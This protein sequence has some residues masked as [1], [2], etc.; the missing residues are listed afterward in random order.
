M[1]PFP[2]PGVFSHSDNRH[3]RQHLCLLCVCV[4]AR[5]L[6]VPGSSQLQC[7]SATS[8]LTFHLLSLPA[9]TA[10]VNT[11]YWQPFSCLPFYFSPLLSPSSV[12]HLPSTTLMTP[13][14]LPFFLLSSQS[15]SP[16]NLPLKGFPIDLMC[17]LPLQ[18]SLLLLTFLFYLRF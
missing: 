2:P 12:F 15:L 5:C 11:H 10:R 16:V 4:C 8:S 7:A 13:S 6:L 1:P 14:L 9:I 18:L 17:S 3:L